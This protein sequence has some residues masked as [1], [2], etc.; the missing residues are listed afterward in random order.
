MEEKCI[1]FN[2]INVFA[3]TIA[4]R[5]KGEGITHVVGLARGGLVPATIISYML[6]K[7]LLTYGISS[8]KGTKKTENFHISQPLNIAALKENNAHVLV[9]DDICDTGDTMR[10]ITTNFGLGAISYKTAC[11]LTKEK[12]KEWLDH[13]GLVAPDNKWIVFPWE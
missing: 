8:Y 6:D 4:S 11:I 9:V 2:E 3:R 13:Y 10:Y 5:L 7:P 12:H 1:S